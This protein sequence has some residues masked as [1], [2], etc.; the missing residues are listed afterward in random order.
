MVW[1]KVSIYNY[2]QSQDSNKQDKNSQFNPVY[3]P[4][5][6]QRHYLQWTCPVSKS[7]WQRCMLMPMPHWLMPLQC[8]QNEHILKENGWELIAG[9]PSDVKCIEK[10]N[11]H[12]TLSSAKSCK[13]TL[14]CLTHFSTIPPLNA[15]KVG[16]FE[17]G[18]AGISNHILLI[19][20][21]T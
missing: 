20:L 3:N 6:T 5:R 19:Q 11:T 8:Q 12:R 18:E 4:K 17:S 15:L 13:Y 7:W 21:I 16:M 2:L 14:D 1:L 10:K 9:E